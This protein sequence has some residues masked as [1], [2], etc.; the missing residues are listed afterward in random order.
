MVGGALME[1]VTNDKGEP[2]GMGID[3]DEIDCVGCRHKSKTVC[4]RFPPV[5]T[6]PIPLASLGGPKLS[7]G[8]WSF[9]P[10]LRKCGEFE[11][12]AE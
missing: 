11:R 9:P 1:L 8:G 3:L 4:K 2:I 10:A 12:G 6:S 7:Q 5:W